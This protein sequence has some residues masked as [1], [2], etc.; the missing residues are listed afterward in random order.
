MSN[1]AQLSAS[2]PQPPH[3]FPEGEPKWELS[4]VASGR[5]ASCLVSCSWLL[6]SSRVRYRKFEENS[7][8]LRGL[9]LVVCDREDRARDWEGELPPVVF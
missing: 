4:G 9:S 3:A 6:S 8:K 1:S 5:R 2:H 7:E